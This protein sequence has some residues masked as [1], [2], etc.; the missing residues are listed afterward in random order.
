MRYYNSP[1][2]LIDNIMN[3]SPF[4]ER[5]YVV[6]DTQYRELRKN[7]AED[8]IKTLEKRL[9]SYESTAE[10][11]RETISKLKEEHG[12]LPAASED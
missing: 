11:L 4:E 5:V 3:I 2:Q 6:S 9:Q 7:Q 8:E 1:F 10:C 12:L